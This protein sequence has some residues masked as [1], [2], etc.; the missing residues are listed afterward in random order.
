LLDDTDVENCCVEFDLTIRPN[1]PVLLECKKSTV[2][3]S[4][5][6]NP[7]MCSFEDTRDNFGMGNEIVA[8]D[9]EILESGLRSPASK[10]VESA[11][12]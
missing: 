10:E 3:S 4:F 2:I 7:I 11:S 5:D 6:R 9:D 1:D 8:G 12:T